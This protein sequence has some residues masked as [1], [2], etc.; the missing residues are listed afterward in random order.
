MLAGGTMFEDACSANCF[1][2]PELWLREQVADAREQLEHGKPILATLHRTL[3]LLQM[4]QARGSRFLSMA[5]VCI[6]KESARKCSSWTTLNVPSMETI[7]S[8]IE[9]KNTELR[10][11]AHLPLSLQLGI[12]TKTQKPSPC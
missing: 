1:P 10:V 6:E 5:T 9:N 11:G 12:P 8:E 7:R 2:C 4:S 3:R